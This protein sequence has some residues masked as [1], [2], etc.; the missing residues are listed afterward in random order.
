MIAKN[1]EEEKRKKE[2]LKKKTEEEKARRIFDEKVENEKATHKKMMEQSKFTEK[3]NKNVIEK[4]HT[5][6]AR[7]SRVANIDCV[8]ADV[9]EHSFRVGLLEQSR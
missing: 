6:S 3:I 9:F 8:D 5:N 1:K 2:E 4:V 7:F